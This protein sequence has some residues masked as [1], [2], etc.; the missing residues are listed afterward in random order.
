MQNLGVGGMTAR[1]PLWDEIDRAFLKHGVHPADQTPEV[2]LNRIAGKCVLAWL[3]PESCTVQKEAIPFKD[4]KTLKRYDDP[5][6]PPAWEIEPIVVLKIE[7]NRY[8]IDGRR[9]VWKWIKDGVDRSRT[10]II[11][12]PKQWWK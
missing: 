2:K 4:L 3:C 12:T 11:I 8:V 1:D 10:A 7:G 5:K 9:R 6:G